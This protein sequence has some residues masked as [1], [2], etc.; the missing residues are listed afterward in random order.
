MKIRPLII[1][2]LLLLIEDLFFYPKLKKHLSTHIDDNS[3]IFDVGANKG[4][5]IRF[6]RS[7]SKY[8]KIFSFEPNPTLFKYLQQQFHSDSRIELNQSGVSNL[9]TRISNKPIGLNKQFS[10]TQ[11]QLHLS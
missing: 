7:I 11:I 1:S 8:A 9:R 3:I 6:F 5:S 10:K 4:Q 2:K